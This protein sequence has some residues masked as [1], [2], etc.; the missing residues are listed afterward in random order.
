[1]YLFSQKW[2]LAFSK[3]N[4]FPKCMWLKQ[5][6]MFSLHYTKCNW[7]AWLRIA[8][9]WSYIV[10]HYL[11]SIQQR[12]WCSWYISTRSDI[13]WFTFCSHDA[14]FQHAEL[15]YFQNSVLI[16]GRVL[17]IIASI[18]IIHLSWIYPKTWQGYFVQNFKMVEQRRTFNPLRPS[19]A[20]ISIVSCNGLLP[21]GTKPLPEPMLTYHQ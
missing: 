14:K 7:P 16:S 20:W 8:R 17:F 9:I 3:W 18:S 12:W 21:D 19:D 4:Q 5:T 1:M 2:L 10:S 13:I 6:E 15:F 11:L